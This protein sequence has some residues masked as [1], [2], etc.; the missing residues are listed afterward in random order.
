MPVATVTADQELT[1]SV[2]EGE[3]PRLRLSVTDRLLLEADFLMTEGGE[4]GLT[5]AKGRRRE[6]R[7][8]GS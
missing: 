8:R 3:E 6:R 2:G 4:G 5:N 7:L 1:A